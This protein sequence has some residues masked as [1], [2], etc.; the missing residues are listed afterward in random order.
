M[1]LRAACVLKERGLLSRLGCCARN[2][3][4]YG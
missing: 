2:V 3:V 4:I 1:E